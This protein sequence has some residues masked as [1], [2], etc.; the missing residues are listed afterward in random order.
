M[1][2]DTEGLDIVGAVG[3]TGEVTKIELDLI[4]ALIESHGHSANEW[5][6]SGR[7]LVVGGSEAAAHVLVIKHLHLKGEI[8]LQVLDDH[9]KEGQLDS[10]SLVCVCWA[11]DV[12]G[13][14]V[15]SHDLEH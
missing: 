3:S 8:L 11:S 13:R 5:L 15:S 1:D 4:P 9:H 12:V 7:A 2:L 6:H 10:E 14:H